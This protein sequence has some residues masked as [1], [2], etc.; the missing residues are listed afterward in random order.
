MF[1]GLPNIGERHTIVGSGSNA[2]GQ[3]AQLVEQGIENPCVLGSIPRLA[4]INTKNPASAGFF[5]P[6]ELKNPD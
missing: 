1:T 4:T 5:M 3:L 2:R 6:K